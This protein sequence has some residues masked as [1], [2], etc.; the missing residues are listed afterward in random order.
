MLWLMIITCGG[1]LYF[2]A[3]Y[4][5]W[6]PTVDLNRPRIL[7]YH[8]VRPDGNTR[9][10]RVRGVRVTP[11]KFEAQI[12]WLA[13]RNWNFMTLG[14]L[15][16]QIPAIPAKTVVI[17]FDDGYADNFRYALPVLRRHAAKATLFLVSRRLRDHPG[18][19]LL[20]PR[21]TRDELL[22]TEEVRKMI[23]SGL[24]E[25]GSHTL[26]HCDFAKATR[27]EKI[28]QLRASREQLEQRFGVPVVSFAYPWGRF[29]EG[30]P[31]LV[32]AAGYT[33]AVT[34]QP[35]IAGCPADDLFRLP[36]VKIS[37]KDRW[38]NLLALRMRVR[39]GRRGLRK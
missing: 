3:R 16:E 26:D 2:S 7:M 4:A 14:E 37:G 39:G 35:G 22:D 34:T 23:A 30:D 6:R 25:L 21:E 31:E 27:E 24:I 36:R 38:G 9:R 15:V 17:T 29:V 20:F 1:L 19:P 12:R 18:E 13:Q 8:S 11:E 33:S 10:R 28:D 5:W 32:A